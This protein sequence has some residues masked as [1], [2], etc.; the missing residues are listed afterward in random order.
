MNVRKNFQHLS[1]FFLLS[2]FLVPGRAAGLSA[3]PSITSQLANGGSMTWSTFVGGS[4]DDDGYDIAVDLNGNSYITGESHASWGTPVNAYAGGISDVF[5]AKVNGQGVLVWNTFLGGVAEDRG[6]GIEVDESG[7]VYITGYSVAGWGTPLDPYAGSGDAFVARLNNSGA[8]VWNTFLG[9][10]KFD[11]GS[12]IAVDG[13]GNITISGTSY[14]AWGAPVNPYAA[15]R[16]A[17]VARLSGSGTLVWNSFL[18]GL[19]YDIGNGIAVDGNGNAAATGFSSSK[20]GSPVNPYAYL[21]DAFVAWLDS[22]GALVWNTFLGGK[23]SNDQGTRIAIDRKGQVTVTGYGDGTWGAPVDPYAGGKDAFAARLDSGGSLVWNTFLGGSAVDYGI[24]IAVDG[25]ANVYVSG[26]SDLGWGT[27]VRPFTGDD[28]AFLARLDSNGLLAWNTFLGGGGRDYGLGV[29]VHQSGD[30]YLGGW[31]T[32]GWG[33]PVRAYSGGEDAFIVKLGVAG[34]TGTYVSIGAHDGWVVE[35]TEASGQGGAMN[36]TAATF[37]LGDNAA[38]KQYRAILSFNTSGLPDQAVFTSV[39]LKI[40][41]QG[42]VGTDPF[43]THMDLRVDIRRPF[44][45]ASA[46]LALSDFQAEASQAAAAVFNKKPTADGWYSAVLD[47]GA[48]SFINPGGT[49]QFRLRFVKDDNNDL[50]ADYLKFYSGNA[51]NASVRPRLIIR[52]YVP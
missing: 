38:D 41:K 24:N 13:K 16:D 50:S 20:W 40:K 15:G 36:A 1:V 43:I 5:V 45:G 14:E 37:I 18:G 9:G 33:T 11:E 52:Y 42:L 27:P 19:R 22:N 34:M 30:V 26:S 25:N 46:T 8:R 17:F 6:W 10:A 29:V 23:T 28:D 39:T 49:T 7:N 35:K 47:P 32:S 12:D 3:G 44:F 2:L 31:G 51:L 4:G 48:Y 21:N